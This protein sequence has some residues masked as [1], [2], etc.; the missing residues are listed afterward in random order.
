MVGA[1]SRRATIVAICV[2]I[3]VVLLL[4]GCGGDGAG[5]GQDPLEQAPDDTAPESSQPRA[6]SGLCATPLI[7]AGI[8]IGGSGKRGR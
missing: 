2:L 7:L 1:M 4:S 3:S 6:D 5:P 8:V